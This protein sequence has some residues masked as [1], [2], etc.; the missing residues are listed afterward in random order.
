[1][2]IQL[3]RAADFVKDVLLLF[4]ETTWYYG[5]SKVEVKSDEVIVYDCPPDGKYRLFRPFP[6]IDDESVKAAVLTQNM[7]NGAYPI[8][9]VLFE[10]LVQGT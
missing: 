2:E 1:M 7:C 5:V 9:K 6:K 3:E 10:Q 8:V 4:L